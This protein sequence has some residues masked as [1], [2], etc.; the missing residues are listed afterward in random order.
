MS[1]FITE[2]EVK[3][4]TVLPSNLS[5]ELLRPWFEPAQNTYIKPLIGLALYSELQTAIDNN[6]LT[7]EQTALLALIKPSLAY[8]IQAMSL[9]FIHTQ[10]SNKGVLMRTTDNGQSIDLNALNTLTT[11]VMDVAENY[12][13]D[14]KNYLECNKAL[15]PSYR[16]NYTTTNIKFSGIQFDNKYVNCNTC[17]YYNCNCN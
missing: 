14:L 1:Y 13:N 3:L 4:K 17:G 8:Y 16:S 9:P 5:I 2:A 6:T 11:K 10:A 15:Y 7:T 12:A